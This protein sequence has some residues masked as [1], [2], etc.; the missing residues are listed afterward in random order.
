MAPTPPNAQDQT[1]A[2]KSK[3]LAFFL[4]VLFSTFSYAVAGDTAN[5]TEPFWMLGLFCCALA[6]LC[7][8]TRIE[9]KKGPDGTI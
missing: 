9:F 2:A 8:G 3:L 5:A 6:A 4:F 1:F 7:V